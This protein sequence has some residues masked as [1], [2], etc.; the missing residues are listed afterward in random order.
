MNFEEFNRNIRKDH[1]YTESEPQYQNVEKVKVVLEDYTITTVK[2]FNPET[3]VALGVNVYGNEYIMLKNCEH[4]DDGILD[5]GFT[6]EHGKKAAK[7]AGVKSY[8]PSRND[9]LRY[10]DNEKIINS[11][12]LVVNGDM[13]HLWDWYWSSTERSED[14]AWAFDIGI[15]TRKG[16]GR[17]DFPKL[18]RAFLTVK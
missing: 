11:A 8:L 10:L 7:E 6:W 17:K 2:D 9:W 15:T 1:Y 3:M 5:C 14:L 18:V 13:V 16:Y 4:T 12:I